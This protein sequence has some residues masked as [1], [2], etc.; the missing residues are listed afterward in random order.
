MAM[1]IAVPAHARAQATLSEAAGAHFPD[2]TYALTLPR[3]TPLTADQVEV[4]E[5]GRVVDDVEVSAADGAR[6][7][8]FG[9]VLA[10]DTSSSMRGAPLR[11]AI[12]AA[13]AFVAHR[14]PAQPVAVVTFGGDVTVLL[15]FTTNR[16]AIEVALGAIDVTGGG[17]RILDATVRSVDLIKASRI[18]SG[19]V[20]VL[21]DGADRGSVTAPERVNQLATKAGARVFGVGLS[22]RSHDFRALNL[23]AVG[24]QGEFTTAESLSDLARV[25]ERLGSRLSHQYLLE[26][27]SAAQ[28]GRRVRVEVKAE[29]IPGVAVA[30]YKT[31]ALSG[32]RPPFHRAPADALWLSPSTALLLS[33]VVGGL[34]VGLLWVLIRPRGM[35]LR[36]RMASYVRE[37]DD[38]EEAARGTLLAGRLRLGAER[39]FERLSWATAFR[40]KLDVGRITIPAERLLAWTT[41]GT[42]GLL[43]LFT[44]VASPALGLLALAVPVGTYMVI[45]RKVRKQRDLFTEQLPDNL[46]MI[47][48]AM[49]AGHSF[50]AA[51]N[52]VID[53][54]PDPTRGE[55]R[56]V[57][58]DERLG[59]PLDVALGVV[60][61]RMKSK[62]FEQV[63]LV[64][65]LQRE[66]GGNTAEVLERVTETVRD[67]L[68]LRRT[69]N[70]LTAQGRLSRWVL[71]AIPIVLLLLTTVINPA[72]VSPLYHTGVGQAF[73]V[74]AG[75]MVLAGSLVI[76]RIVNIKV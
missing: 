36:E 4:R 68:A 75:L 5:N 17:S 66:T 25:Y 48:S 6:A 65:A 74:T 22:S 40:E 55:L 59:V 63:A 24:T 2:R 42:I 28:P 34:L 46:Q 21:S 30:V 31:P 12:E 27:H 53:D 39:S 67:R 33:V 62:E 70:T 13:R 11:G 29:G 73:L 76:K 35:S 38:A 72:Y 1:A 23:L 18:A 58:A 15:P 19:S 7:S 52:V 3:A 71:T 14:S 32:G 49:R 47:A 44:T 41:L 37:P 69:V 57:V 20:V 8:R 43:A 10:I 9:V 56:R 16:R 64:A 45:E 60:V 61:R 54:A 50:A 51:L 26:Y